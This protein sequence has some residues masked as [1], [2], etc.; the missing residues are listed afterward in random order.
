MDWKQLNSELGN[1][2]LYW[3]DFIL[4]GYLPDNAKVLDA[5]CG[6][7]RNLIYCLKNGMDVFGVDQNLEAIEFLK[8]IA[9]Q[10]KYDNIDGRFQQMKLDKLVFPPQSFDV[11][12]CSAVLHFAESSQHF[13]QMLSEIIRVLKPGGRLFIRTMTDEYLPEKVIS[14][15]EQVYLFPAGQKRYVIQ[16]ENFTQQL[17]KSELA[18]IEPYKEVVVQER[19]TMGTFMFESQI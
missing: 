11:I 13:Q 12:I 18:L 19:H 8:R 2:D 15:E 3:L 7:G 1:I 10:F 17:K 4:K 14:L 6:E 9:K 16:A 5:G